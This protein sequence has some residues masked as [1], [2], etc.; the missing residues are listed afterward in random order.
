M[1]YCYCHSPCSNICIRIKIIHQQIAVSMCDASTCHSSVK[2]AVLNSTS[3]PQENKGPK[4]KEATLTTNNKL[5][6][7]YRPF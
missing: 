1:K 6:G 7:R 2:Q 3:A 4:G 5:C